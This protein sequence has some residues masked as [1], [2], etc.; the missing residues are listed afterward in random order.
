MREK[1]YERN[2]DDERPRNREI[3]TDVP[4]LDSDN[5][6]HGILNSMV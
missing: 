3:V 1:Q 6:I 2:E 5:V 4:D